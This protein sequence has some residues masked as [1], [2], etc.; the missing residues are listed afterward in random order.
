MLDREI[1][2][3]FFRE[4]D[5]CPGLERELSDKTIVEYRTKPRTEV[6]IHYTILDE[7]GG[8]DGY[9]S[10]YM[11]EAYGGVCF[12]AFV[13]F[14]GE[15]LQY[16][17]TEEREGTF[18]VTGSGTLQR[19]DNDAVEESRYQMINDIATAQTIQDYET[20]DQLL[21]ESTEFPSPPT[22]TAPSCWMAL[23]PLPA[24][25]PRSK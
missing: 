10:E 23:C 9:R 6:C 8:T 13:L 25:L 20:M 21:E 5:Q 17:I 19:R 2:L 15:Y 22:S 18:Q 14:F 7:N 16:Y 11:R 24:G 12:K 3:D 4:F 1:Y